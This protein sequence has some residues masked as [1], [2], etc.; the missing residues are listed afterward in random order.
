MGSLG[1]IF[2]FEGYYSVSVWALL[3]ALTI[4]LFQTSYWS[5]LFRMAGGAD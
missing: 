3:Y 4:I 2:Y 5:V 1:R